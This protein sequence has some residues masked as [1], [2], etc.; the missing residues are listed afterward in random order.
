MEVPQ[1]IAGLHEDYGLQDFV[2][3]HGDNLSIEQSEMNEGLVRLRLQSKDDSIRPIMPFDYIDVIVAPEQGIL[4]AKTTT[5]ISQWTSYGRH[6]VMIPGEMM[7]HYIY[8]PDHSVWVSTITDPW[9]EIYAEQDR[10]KALE[11]RTF[12]WPS[13]YVKNGL[14][15]AYFPREIGLRELHLE[16][17]KDL[18]SG[19]EHYKADLKD[20]SREPQTVHMED[21]DLEQKTTFAGAISESDFS[22]FVES[23]EGD[24]WYKVPREFPDLVS[25]TRAYKPADG[26]ASMV[27]E[28]V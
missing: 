9:Q 4:G 25:I 23:I 28:I 14:E 17:I 22:R 27:A 7:Q 19:N 12:V 6:T 20:F 21:D 18:G 10:F 16:E 15:A 8:V 5:L 2:E 11:F 13:Q 1:I 26:P 3:Y 24:S